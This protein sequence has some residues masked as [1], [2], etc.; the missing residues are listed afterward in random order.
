MII[1]IYSKQRIFIHYT[2]E[3]SNDLNNSDS[4]NTIFLYNKTLNYY[5]INKNSH[6]FINVMLGYV[7][8]LILDQ[9]ESPLMDLVILTKD[10][11]I[12]TPALGENIIMQLLLNLT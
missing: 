8:L 5:L 9:L 1:L 11:S 7:L 3:N 2:V 12:P 4:N 10:G 6:I